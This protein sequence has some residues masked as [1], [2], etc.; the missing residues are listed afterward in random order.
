MRNDGLDRE[1]DRGTEPAALVSPDSQANKNSETIAPQSAAIMRS[2]FRMAA[3]I[4]LARR[5]P[6]KDNKYEIEDDASDL[7]IEAEFRRRLS[8]LRR[9][10]Q[11]DR[12]HALRAAKTQRQVALKV[13]QEKRAYDRARKYA[14]RKQQAPSPL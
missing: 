11:R 14:L 5:S 12:A 9:M 3:A 10:P 7:D 8:A 2:S 4:D 1:T 13:L 6:A